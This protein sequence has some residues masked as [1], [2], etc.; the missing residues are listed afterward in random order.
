[1]KKVLS[2]FLACLLVLSLGAIHVFAAE[3]DTAAQSDLTTQ[4]QSLFS[5]QSGDT[6]RID[7]SKFSDTVSKATDS[8]RYSLASSILG[9]SDYLIVQNPSVS[10]D[11]VKKTYPD[12]NWTFDEMELE[13]GRYVNEVQAVDKNGVT[14]KVKVDAITSEIVSDTI[15]EAASAAATAK[16]ATASDAAATAEAK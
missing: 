5:G 12:L 15:A 13:N 8:T 9:D 14:Q 2:L 16:T 6:Q 1:M 11:V 4:L 10:V 7:I 3:T